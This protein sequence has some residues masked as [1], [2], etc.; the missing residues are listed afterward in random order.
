ME[1]LW[2]LKSG[3]KFSALAIDQA[4]EQ[5]NAVIKGD[6]GAICVTEDPSVLRRQMVAGPEVSHL[7]AEYEVASGAKEATEN[8]SHHDR[9]M[10]AQRIFLEKVQ[11]S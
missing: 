9:A 8:T 11:A 2:Y 1:I 10:Q 7:V 4:H 6:G 5:A 3:S